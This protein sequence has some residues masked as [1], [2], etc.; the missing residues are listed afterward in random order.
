MSEL[1]VK[2]IDRVG[3]FT[4]SKIHLLIP[5]SRPYKGSGF[6]KGGYTYIKQRKQ[7]R[8]RKGSLSVDAS[9]LATAWGDLMEQV[10]YTKLG[11]IISNM[12]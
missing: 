9:T 3:N 1:I 10:C 11:S 2:N 6:Q 7:E 12:E 8:K 5:E 4:S